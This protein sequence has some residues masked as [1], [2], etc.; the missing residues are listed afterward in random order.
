M[1]QTLSFVTVF[2]TGLLHSWPVEPDDQLDLFSLEP[3]PMAESDS[4]NLFLINQPVEADGVFGSVEPEEFPFNDPNDP[5]LLSN[6]ASST[7]SHCVGGS[8]EPINVARSLDSLQPFDIAAEKDGFCLKDGERESPP[9][10]LTLP[11]SLDDLDNLLKPKPED[12]IPPLNEGLRYWICA[13]TEA[14]VVCCKPDRPKYITRA[15][16]K[17]CTFE[18]YFSS[19][20][21]TSSKVSG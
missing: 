2:L 1:R 19:V 14:K 9:I 12:E 3:N 8:M 4:T 11:N 13:K 6:G 18:K 10:K 21:C 20:L 15:G 17:L 5:I 16:C 7:V